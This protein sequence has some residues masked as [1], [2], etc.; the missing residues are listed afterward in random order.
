MVAEV[1]LAAGAAFTAVIVG[2]VVSGGG[3]PELTWNEISRRVGVTELFDVVDDT[4]YCRYRALAPTEDPEDASGVKLDHVASGVGT[5]PVRTLTAWVVPDGTSA[6][7]VAVPHPVTDPASK[8]RDVNVPEVA[9]GVNR[10]QFTETFPPPKAKSLMS[11]RICGVITTAWEATCWPS[12][13]YVA[14]LDVH[15]MR[16]RCGDPSQPPGI[17]V[18]VP[19]VR[20]NRP[21]PPPAVENIAQGWPLKSTPNPTCW[22]A[23]PLR[24]AA[25]SRIRPEE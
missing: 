23:A 17:C 19:F 13:K 21:P 2:G 9:Y 18:D 5:L 6:F 25:N 3:G 8:T 11:G 10:I 12:M 1:P 20:A 22:W 14:P 7:H 16:N 24:V 15:S 4:R